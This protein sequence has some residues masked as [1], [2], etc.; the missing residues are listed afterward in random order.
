MGIFRKK[1]LAASIGLI[2]SSG[3]IAAPVS[4]DA[5]GT[6]VLASPT[7]IGSFDWGQS[8]FL[9]QGGQAA[10]AA[11]IGT[12]GACGGTVASPGTLCNFTVYTHASLSGIKDVNGNA[13]P[14]PAGLNSSYEI[15]MVAAFTER[16]TAVAGTIASFAT[17]PGSTGFLE[18]Y[19]G[20]V[21]SSAVDGMGFNDGR[22][23]L[24]G[25]TIGDAGGLFAVT[26][27]TSPFLP[28]DGNGAD[29]YF[30]A[31]NTRTQESVTGTGSNTDIPVSNLTVDTTYFLN[32]LSSAGIQFANISQGL[33]FSTVDPSDCFTPAVSATAIGSVRAGAIPCAADHVSDWY[34]A[35]GVQANGGILPNT[36][37]VNGLFVIGDLDPDFVAQTDFNSPLRA[38]IPE[39]STLALLA[40]A[41]GLLGGLSRRRRKV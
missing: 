10:I 31:A 17:L 29:A 25:T 23:I 8:S 37:P 20:A 3:V 19:S 32:G 11:F 22:L 40:G 30:S 2:C 7:T 21:N 41:L 13:L 4:F 28:L 39:P 15:T 27:N 24:R 9:A 18:I 26:D 16:V 34:A 38:D 33:P 36:G 1:V 5:D 6:G 14:N 12:G 35:Q